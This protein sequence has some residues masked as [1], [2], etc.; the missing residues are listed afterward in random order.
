VE[1]FRMKREEPDSQERSVG[2][3]LVSRTE[4]RGNSSNDLQRE[5]PFERPAK[6]VAGGPHK[7]ARSLFSK[8]GDRSLGNSNERQKGGGSGKIQPAPGGEYCR[9][10]DCKHRSVEVQLRRKGSKSKEGRFIGR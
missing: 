1:E 5:R 6:G 4:G 3:K 7:N 9:L 8:A 10:K 2:K